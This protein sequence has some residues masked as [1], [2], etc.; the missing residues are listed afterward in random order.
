MQK[1]DEFVLLHVLVLENP[2][3]F[4]REDCTTECGNR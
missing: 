1:I 4:E 3:E 2:K